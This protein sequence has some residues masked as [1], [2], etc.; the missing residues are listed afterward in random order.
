MTI[1]SFQKFVRSFLHSLSCTLIGAYIRVPFSTPKPSLCIFFV[2]SLHTRSQSADI[3]TGGA[4]SNPT[5]LTCKSQLHHLIF[6]AYDL[7][8]QQTTFFF[9]FELR[10]WAHFVRE[11]MTTNKC[12]KG[13]SVRKLAS[14]LTVC[15]TSYPPCRWITFFFSYE[16]KVLAHFI[17]KFM[18]IK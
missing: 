16:L 10:V 13:W 5:T 9:S 1:T 18:T 11:L 14:W 7:P 6:Y 4:F 3:Y 17:R 2:N 15:I 12:G 8:D